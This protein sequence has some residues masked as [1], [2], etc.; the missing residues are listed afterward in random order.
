MIIYK[1]KSTN[2]Y[3]NLA[4]EQYLLDTSNDSV[5]MLWQN[6]KSVII[7]KNQNAYAELNVDYTEKNGIKVVRRLTGGGAVFHDI[8]NINFTFIVPAIENA[9]LDFERFTCPIIAAIKA[10]GVNDVCLSGRNDIMLNGFKISGNAQ[11]SYNGKTL[12]HGTLLYSA[13]LSMLSQALR[14]DEEKI[15]SKGIKSVRNRV[16]NIK[17]Y[18]DREMTPDE[19]T[20]YLEQYISQSFKCEIKSFTDEDIKKINE[21][22][23]NKYS[24][25]DWNFGK[26]KEM[27]AQKKKRYSFGGVCIDFSVVG[28]VIK[29]LKITGDFFG[30]SDVNIIE[31]CLIGKK[32]DSHL[33]S[34]ALDESRIYV[35]HCIAGMDNKMLVELI[36][37]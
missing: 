25:W 2:P 35:P 1:N 31:E 8:G 10:L 12:H 9:T 36:M 18:I 14:V 13:D 28:G 16:G 21:L 33:L 23:S 27:S 11:S 26:S 32:F 4:S 20:E 34:Q 19:F 6:E 7:G 22:A 30:N 17:D 29:S 24:T 5:F 15:K 37:S 3:F